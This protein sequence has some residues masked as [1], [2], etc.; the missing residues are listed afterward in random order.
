MSPGDALLAIDRNG[1]GVV[2][3]ISELSFLADA[4]GAL[5]DLQGLRA[6]D[7]N[8]DGAL[9]AQDEAW[10]DFLVWSDDDGNGVSETGELRTLA[11]A[12]IQ[13]INLS[14]QG[15]P[16]ADMWGNVVHSYADVTRTDGSTI[17][18]ADVSFAYAEVSD[19]D[20]VSD[21]GV[22]GGTTVMSVAASEKT[23]LPDPLDDQP[24]Q[25][26]LST[27]PQPVPP[28]AEPLQWQGHDSGPYA[29]E[30]DSHAVFKNELTNDNVLVSH[31][32]VDGWQ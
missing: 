32:D 26:E 10:A 29:F 22:I 18:A 4:P 11:D 30:S 5:T 19:A 27:S 3:G 16:F 31:G 17:R 7:S 28:E 15:Q 20:D 25:F 8:Q 12:G 6:Y 13:S 1:D 9:S 23:T 2:N 24:V 14:G 21:L